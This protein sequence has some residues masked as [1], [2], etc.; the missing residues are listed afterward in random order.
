MPTQ[1][2]KSLLLLAALIARRSEQP[3]GPTP[4]KSFSVVTVM[5]AAWAS[6]AP[7]VRPIAIKPAAHPAL[8][9]QAPH[10]SPPFGRQTKQKQERFGERS[11]CRESL[12][13]ALP[14]WFSCP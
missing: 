9:K 4:K 2:L 3:V 12:C 14:V 13:A 7:S 8:A 11:C 1:P 6:A 5:V 10:G